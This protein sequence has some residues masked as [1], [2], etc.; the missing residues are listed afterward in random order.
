LFVVDLE[1]LS[2]AIV[3]LGGNSIDRFRQL[4]E[5][6]F[7]ESRISLLDIDTSLLRCNDL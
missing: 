5:E 6:L 1:S 7:D 2:D 3:N 4:K